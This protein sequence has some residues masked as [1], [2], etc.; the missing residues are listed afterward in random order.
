MPAIKKSD[1]EYT[2][3]PPK[4]I[5]IPKSANKAIDELTFLSKDVDT[6][7]LIDSPAFNIPLAKAIKKKFPN[8]RI[9]YYILPKVWAWKRKRAKIVREYCDE[10]C[11]I[12]P[13]EDEFF[14]DVKYVGN[15]L[16]DE[17]TVFN[18]GEKKDQVSFLP[19]SRKSEIKSLM[20]VFREL[21]KKIDARKVLVVP[22]FFN[23]DDIERLYGDVREFEISFDM[24]ESISGSDFAF[25][26]SGTATL[27]SAII[28]TPFVLAYKAKKLDYFLGKMFV[29]L[30]FVG[31]ANII[32]HFLNKEPIHEEFLQDDV[33][34]ENLLDSYN[35]HDREKFIAVSKK[36]KDIFKNGSVTNMIKILK[37][38]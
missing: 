37:E 25:I 8:K 3:N 10:L 22:K 33:N 29:K 36:L 27:E 2:M 7:L 24:Q 30:P 38:K 20:P 15:P 21:S 14:E 26:C 5:S 18:N 17:I 34:V 9:V 12:F 28:G 13:F 4:G 19:G 23:N 11:S 6:V 1:M 31:L 16:L 32:M 35:S